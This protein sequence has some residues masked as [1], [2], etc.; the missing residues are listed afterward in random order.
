MAALTRLSLTKSLHSQIIAPGS[1][2]TLAQ[3][4]LP[5]SFTPARYRCPTRMF[6]G[7]KD[8]EWE[9]NKVRE[10]STPRLSNGVHSKPDVEMQ[11]VGAD[12]EEKPA[13]EE[14][15]AEVSYE[16]DLATDEGAV[17]PMRG[18]RVVDWPCF[19]A[20]LKHIYKTLSPHFH[21][22]V[23]VISQPI[24]SAK[25]HETITMFF[26][27]QFQIPAFCLMDSAL[28]ACYAYGVQSATVVDVGHG[29]CDVTA[30]SEF[31]VNE[32]G[33]GV[34]IPGCG[35]DGM[36]QRLLQSLSSKGFTYQ[37]CEQLKKSPIC[38]VLPAGTPLPGETAV[39]SPTEIT[40]PAAAASTGASGSGPERRESINDAMPRGPGAGTEVGEEANGD[41]EE[42]EGV[43][44]IATIVARGN[45]SEFLAK[46]EKEKAEKAAAKKAASAAEAVARPA[47]L[48]NAKRDRATFQFE[49]YGVLENGDASNGAGPPKRQRREIE[50]GV[51]RFLAAA[52]TT[53]AKTDD[54]AGD[55]IIETIAS[56]IHSTVLAVPDLSKR[57]ELWDSLI[58]LGNGSKV[59]GKQSPQTAM[60]ATFKFAMLIAI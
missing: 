36:T 57:S 44:D 39:E 23:M 25:D 53:T 29:K 15:E 3:L 60:I 12:G 48:P 24:W 19:F 10:K 34:A 46:R 26:F 47:R 40:N 11:E 49:E 41:E 56:T 16:E 20:L 33:R 37:M 38:E 31:V 14:V 6:P 18:G 52:P 1:Q 54:R 50:V 55:S 27:Q 13:A 43:I 28:A 45:T 58:I 5:E 8:G 42:N 22:P 21:T 4:G 2:T 17:W 35:G 30:V 59:R 32:T 7:E 9:P 51:E